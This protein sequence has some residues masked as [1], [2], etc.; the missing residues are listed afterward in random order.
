MAIVEWRANPQ[1]GWA[2][3]IAATCKNDGPKLTESAISAAWR[4][5]W[6][7]WKALGKKLPGEMSRAEDAG[8]KSVE[9]DAGAEPQSF[10][11]H[12]QRTEAGE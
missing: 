5:S 4:M 6:R 10:Q 8:L 12:R 3:Q 7:G 11:D 1:E 9:G 2:G